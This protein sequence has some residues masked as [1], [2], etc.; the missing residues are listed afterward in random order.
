MNEFEENIKNGIQ[1]VIEGTEDESYIGGF[2]DMSYEVAQKLIG[3]EYTEEA[4]EFL[5]ALF[6]EIADTA[7]NKGREF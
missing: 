2:W 6:R 7:L 3:D 1:C 5:Y 4:Q